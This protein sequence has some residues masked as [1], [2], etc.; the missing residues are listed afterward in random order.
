[1][2]YTKDIRD[3][4]REKREA[5]GKTLNQFALENGID[6]STLSKLERKEQGMNYKTLINIALGFEDKLST[7][8][9]ELEDKH[10]KY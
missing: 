7:F 3:F 6:P 5:N 1:M 9:K 8:F 10:Y 2:Q 4:I